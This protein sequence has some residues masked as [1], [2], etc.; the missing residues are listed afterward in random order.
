[1][2]QH[3]ARI[4]FELE[5]DLYHDPTSHLE[6]VSVLAHDL[7]AFIDWYFACLLH[8]QIELVSAYCLRTR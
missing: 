1:M 4:L 5:S 8:K 3:L 7:D 2:L 6:S